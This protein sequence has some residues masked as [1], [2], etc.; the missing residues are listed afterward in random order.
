MALSDVNLRIALC[1][2]V[3]LGRGVDQ[4]MPRPVDPKLYE[5]VATSAKDYVQLAET[6]NG[7][8]PRNVPPFYV[9]G[10]VPEVLAEWQPDRTIVNLETAATRRG[11][12]DPKGI[13][14]RMAPEHVPALNEIGV[15]CCVIANNH[16]LDWSQEGLFD[17]LDS[18]SAAQIAFAGA[19]R[20]AAEAA[21][22]AVLGLAGSRRLLVYAF[23]T[24]SSGVPPSW[25]ADA[26]HP[27]VNILP[28]L[29]GD[30]AEAV[31]GRI[32]SDKSPGDVVVVSIHWGGNWGYEIPEYQRRFAHGLLDAGSVDIVHGHS[33]HHPKAIEVR[34]GKPIL[35]GCGDFLND[36]EGIGG[37]EDVRPELV[38]QY[39]LDLGPDARLIRLGMVPFRIRRFRLE[40]PTEAEA[41]WMAVRMDRECRRFGGRVVGNPDGILHLIA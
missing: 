31:A 26:G 27:G 13:N 41:N 25:A 23:A 3:M 30:R 38:L 33:S 4:I 14:Y 36:Y 1:G 17:T 6:A 19:G 22:P 8:I 24:P 9:W 12:P 28:D 20:T 34:N 39:F 32:G 37:H 40:R 35:Y 21:A 15:D 7:Q 11:S 29:S 10:D 5:P 16:V 2:D 18:L